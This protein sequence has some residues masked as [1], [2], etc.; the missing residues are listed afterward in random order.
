MNDE[1]TVTRLRAL[2]DPARWQLVKILAEQ[3]CHQLNLPDA[4]STLT[5]S[6]LCCAVTGSERITSTISHHLNELA[7]AGVVDRERVGRTVRYQ[8]NQEVMASLAAAL[9]L[10]ASLETQTPMKTHISLNVRDIELSTRWYAALFGQSPAKE[11]PGYANF[12]LEQP[13][14]K[15]ALNQIA[16]NQT[17]G[18]GKGPVNH[19][20]IQVAHSENVASAKQRF[21]DAGLV[22]FTEE[23][24]TCCYAVQDKVWV[25]DP[26]G[27]AWEVY[28]VTD[29]LTSPSDSLAASCACGTAET[30]GH[31]GG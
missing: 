1:M 8:L 25:T 30:V 26:D 16:P 3:C 5:A 10:P 29:E 6:E 18:V 2:A 24:V 15:L 12:S 14:L 9:C 21:E 31:I 23:N 4:D 17:E 27:N 19:F 11:R 20:G 22:T 13:P 28:A 7:E